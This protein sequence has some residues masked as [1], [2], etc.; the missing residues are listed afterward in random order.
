MQS[1]I[2]E[3]FK[4]N[5]KDLSII[6]SLII[7]SLV[8]FSSLIAPKLPPSYLKIVDNMF[9]KFLLFTG[10]AYLATCDLVSAIIATI[11]VM[12]T[13]QTLSVHKITDKLI[14]ET[15][16]ILQNNIYQVMNT[17]LQQT[18]N[19]NLQQ[20]TNTNLQQTT[21]TNLQQT[22][23][24]NLQQTTNNSFEIDFEKSQKNVLMSN[25]KIPENKLQ[26]F[27]SSEIKTHNIIVENHLNSTEDPYLKL[28]EFI[29]NIYNTDPTID[30]NDL[31]IAIITSNP[32]LN[33]QFVKEIINNIFL[34]SSNSAEHHLHVLNSQQ[35]ILNQQQQQQAVLNNNNN[36][37]Y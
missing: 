2:S 24:T 5:D 27:M 37:L 28:R 9:V 33:G 26:D 35:P 34:S 32:N 10:I 3:L 25:E 23:N 15:K 30:L 18:T 11:A 20:T 17:N 16:T 29:N 7:I 12:V 36:K 8:I 13:L 22:T 4:G 21:N 31:Y 14:E 6:K 1:N 19:T